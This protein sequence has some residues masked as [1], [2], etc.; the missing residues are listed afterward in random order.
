[1]LAGRLAAAG[2]EAYIPEEYAEQVFSGV[3]A[4]E[5]LTVR[6]AA[7]DYEA[8]KAI[9]AESGEVTPTDV[10][11]GLSGPEKEPGPD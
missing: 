4:L 10:P 7:K 8:A 3:V 5:R 2:I 9:V 6:V 1:M 11:P